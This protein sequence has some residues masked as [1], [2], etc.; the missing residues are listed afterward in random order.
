MSTN[1]AGAWTITGIS[2]TNSTATLAPSRFPTLCDATHL[3]TTP[4]TT[5]PAAAGGLKVIDRWFDVPFDYTAPDREK[6]RVFTRNAISNKDNDNGEEGAKK[7]Y[8][9]Y[10]Q[11]GPGFECSAPKSHP[12]TDFMLGK[13]YQMLYIDQ[14]GT[15]LSTPVSAM[16]LGKKGDVEEQA[17]WLKGLRADNIVRDCEAIRQTLIG[18]QEKADRKKWSVVG[19]SFGGFCSVTYLSFYPEGLREVFTTGGMPPLVD[20]PDPVYERTY[21]SVVQRNAVY[22]KKYPQDVEGVKT[23][24]R[25]LDSKKI[26]LPAGGV[27][28]AERF[29]S[30]GL[31]FGGHGGID[32]V[33]Q[34]IQRVLNEIELFG[35]ISYK[36]LGHIEGVLGFD[37]NPLYAVM[38]EPIYCQGQASN[39]S[40]HRL[41]TD[42]FMWSSNDPQP[43]EPVYFTGEM[44][45][46]HV[47]D[48]YTELRQMKDVANKI[49][50]STDWPP[51]YDVDQLKKNDVPVYAAI[52]VDDMYVDYAFSTETAGTIRGAKTFITNSMHHN[53]IRAKSAEV[54]GKLWALKVEEVD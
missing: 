37:E 12:L 40:A 29:L 50:E 43:T 2:V 24:L 30:L 51:L 14:R 53:A 11:G 45:Y 1:L 19:Q 42:K 18:D 49:A 13:G 17:R 8:C 33:H 41:K 44:V 32:S 6:I 4:Q 27:L 46:P 23:I 47:L 52:Y 34:T 20:N 26:T 48:E 15:G 3:H 9:V 10:L 7:P 21:K 16:S 28:S 35:D 22:Y 36:M 25:F 54:L 38:H 31:S 5:D 39:W